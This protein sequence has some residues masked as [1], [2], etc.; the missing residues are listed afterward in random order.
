MYILVACKKYVPFLSPLNADTDVIETLIQTF[1]FG[2][3]PVHFKSLPIDRNQKF[4]IWIIDHY[5]VE[6]LG[7]VC[8]L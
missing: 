4:S 6:N 3:L 2:I 5:E 8:L 1:H 7:P